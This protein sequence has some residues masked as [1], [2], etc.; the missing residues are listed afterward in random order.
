MGNLPVAFITSHGRVKHQKQSSF[1]SAFSTASYLTAYYGK[2]YGKEIEFAPLYAMQNSKK[3]D[4]TSRQGTYLTSL[5]DCVVTNGCCEQMYYKDT[6][7]QDWNDNKFPPVPKE[8]DENAKKYIP[9]KKVCKKAVK[10]TVEELKKIIYDNSG[11]IFALNIWNNYFKKHKEMFIKAPLKEAT[12]GRHA[13]YVCGFDDELECEY[14]GNLYKGFF[15][16]ADSHGSGGNSKGLCYLPYKFLENKVRGLYSADVLI[17][18]VYYF[19]YE[20]DKVKYPNIHDK[21]EPFRPQRK[22]KFKINEKEAY[23]NNFKNNLKVAPQTIGGYNYI[24]FK[25]LME[26][27]GCSVM[28]VEK[29]KT[30]SAHSKEPNYVIEIKVGDKNYVKRV[31]GEKKVIV[32]ELSPVQ[33]D[34]EIL[35]PVRIVNELLGC[36]MV[37]NAGDKTIT[38]TGRI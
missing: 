4:K 23:Y 14:E 13:I 38:I 12:I 21:N 8:A 29:T 6:L 3:I 1:C 9:Y 11:C 36:E 20:K 2:I 16:L 24:P 31:K 30:A 7:D 17:D 28:M 35:I 26:S 33:I 5:L 37:W 19:E 10:L 34:G 27:L 32:N 15:I 22:I 25:F 18:D